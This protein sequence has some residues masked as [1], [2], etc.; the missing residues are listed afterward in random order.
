M[1][2]WRDEFAVVNESSYSKQQ[3]N[4][5]RPTVS[6]VG[7]ARVAR[8]PRLTS[9]RRG[10]RRRRR[11]CGSG[12][13]WRCCALLLLEEQLQLHRPSSPTGTSAP[14]HPGTAAAGA[15]ATRSN[16]PAQPTSPHTLHR[17]RTVNTKRSRSQCEK[18]RPSVLSISRFGILNAMVSYGSAAKIRYLHT[19]HTSIRASQRI[20]QAP[21][22]NHTVAVCF[23]TPPR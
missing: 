18:N 17:T 9:R 4:P 3:V 14:S 20:D 10:R 2:G 12:R 23:F 16:R 5:T 19:P 6:L 1:R 22:R 13:Q 8:R 21:Q 11:W 15:T 7:S